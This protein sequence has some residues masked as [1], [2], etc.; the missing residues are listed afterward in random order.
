MWRALNMWRQRFGGL[1][2]TV[3]FA[4]LNLAPQ[5]LTYVGIYH[6]CH[7]VIQSLFYNKLYCNLGFRIFEWSM[8]RNDTGARQ[9][10]VSPIRELY[11]TSRI[12]IIKI[13]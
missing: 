8:K 7:F 4:A 3:N 12:E 10:D 2:W 13:C 9:T 1:A 6:S 5:D 11:H